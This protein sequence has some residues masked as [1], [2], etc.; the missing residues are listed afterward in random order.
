M[1]FQ[2]AVDIKMANFRDLVKQA[3]QQTAKVIEQRGRAD[4][5]GKIYHSRKSN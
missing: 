3:A 5:S 2:V 4:I 1:V